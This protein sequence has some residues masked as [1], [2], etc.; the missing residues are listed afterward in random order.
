MVNMSNK[1]TCESIQAASFFLSHIGNVRV[2][3]ELPAC[4][5]VDS[6]YGKVAPRKIRLDNCKANKIIVRN[7]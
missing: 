3:R 5:R 6:L 2:R 4:E 7:A 1:K